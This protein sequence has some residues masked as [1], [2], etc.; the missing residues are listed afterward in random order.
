MRTIS[1]LT[2][3]L[4]IAQQLALPMA[5]AAQGDKTKN[6]PVALLAPSEVAAKEPFTFAVG[7]TVEGEVS[8]DNVVEGE[9][10]SVATVDGEVV[11]HKKADKYGRVFL[12]A[13]LA[14]GTYLVS[15]ANGAKCGGQIIVKQT[16]E[17]LAG[18]HLG[19]TDPPNLCNVQKGLGLKGQGFNPNTGQ[20]TITIGNKQIPVLAG[21]ASELR[22][23]VL[24]PALCGRGPVI[25]KN[26]ESG[27]T[28]RIESLTVFSLK[29]K[30]GRQKL[31]SGEQTI[32]EFTFLPADLSATVSVRILSGPVKFVGGGSEKS[33]KVEHGKATVP[34][35][36][37]PA[38]FGSFRVAY[39]L[40]KVGD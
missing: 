37:D 11:E 16:R 36:A 21:T 28:D 4:L 7:G 6:K 22:T 14:A 29:A 26:A 13:G 39:D 27:E 32:L 15:R 5:L 3:G 18:A 19:I 8:S 34:L 23:G 40:E 38:G 12:A 17:L 20:M 1:F 35:V 30:L 33:V 10:I 25:V 31:V 9:V 24:P 2:A